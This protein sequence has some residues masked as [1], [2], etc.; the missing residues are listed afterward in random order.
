MKMDINK[1]APD[2]GGLSFK[3]KSPCEKKCEAFNGKYFKLHISSQ[4]R[5]RWKSTIFF[6]LKFKSHGSGR[7]LT[8]YG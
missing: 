7:N 3:C 4:T 1:K 2:T 6:T 8:A 5:E